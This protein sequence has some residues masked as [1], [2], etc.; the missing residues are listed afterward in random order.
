LRI[1]EKEARVPAT[2]TL[3]PLLRVARLARDHGYGG[4]ST[5][6]PLSRP[7][8]L[9]GADWLGEFGFTIAEALDRLGP[10]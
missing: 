7:W 9:N 10:D 8:V 1:N 3:A 6:E 4:F 2:S 5:D